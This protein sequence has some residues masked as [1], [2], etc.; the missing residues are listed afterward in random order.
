[1]LFPVTDL[2]EEICEGSLC[3]GVVTRSSIVSDLDDVEE[4]VDPPKDCRTARSTKW[5]PTAT[6]SS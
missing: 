3:G 4:Y 5:P 1:M 6:S 2:D